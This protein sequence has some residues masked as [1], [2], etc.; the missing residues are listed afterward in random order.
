MDGGREDGAVA[1]VDE[2]RAARL[3]PEVDTDGVPA[4]RPSRVPRPSHKLRSALRAVARPRRAEVS[5]ASIGHS[6][7]VALVLRFRI[8]AG[9]SSA[10]RSQTDEDEGRRALVLYDRR[11]MV[12]LIELTLNHGLF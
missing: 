8:M 3:R 2:D 9:R 4:Q 7:D 6:R 10:R 5:V 12:D 1:D 11:A